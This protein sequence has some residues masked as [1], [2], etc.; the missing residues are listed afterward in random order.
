MDESVSGWNASFI[1]FGAYKKYPARWSTLFKVMGTYFLVTITGRSKQIKRSGK[2]S[3]IFQR[4][5]FLA[6]SELMFDIEHKFT[7]MVYVGIQEN[8]ICSAVAGR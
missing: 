1:P 4:D 2:G 7:E 6:N 5:F 8:P 3:D